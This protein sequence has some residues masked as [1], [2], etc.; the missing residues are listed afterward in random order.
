VASPSERVLVTGGSGFTGKHLCAHLRAAGYRVFS[1]T[2]T[3]VGE[4]D[5]IQ[6]DLLD[7]D[8][9]AAAVRDTTPHHVVHLAA[10][11]FPGHAQ[12]NEVYRINL[13]GSLNL[14]AAL[15]AAHCGQQGVVLAS[16]GT[17]Y[18]GLESEALDESAPPA[19]ITHYAV[20]KL[21]ME[22]M[23]RLFHAAVPVTIVRPFN[24]TGPGQR[25]PFLVPKIVRHFAERAGVIELGNLDIVRDFLD[26]RVV[27]EVYRRLL[28]APAQA[29]AVYNLCSGRGIALRDIVQTL[30]SITGHAIEV[31]VNPQFVRVGEPRSIVGSPARLQA[32]IGALPLIPLATTLTD[33]LREREAS[34]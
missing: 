8:A 21:A 17:V 9:L 7:C 14:L 12:A 4:P 1:L 19:P 20:S 15:A 31:R 25:E 5:T 16:T 29:G 23:A 13:E 33:M 6:A 10:I 18:G 32:A 34:S 2:D 3:A 11:S 30:Q 28:A 24:Y 27:I 26:V 22:H